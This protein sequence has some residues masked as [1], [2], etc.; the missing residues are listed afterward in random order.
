M[1]EQHR[2]PRAAARLEADVL[3]AG[4]GAAG[5]TAA[6][7]FGSAGFEVICVDRET[8]RLDPAD[9]GADLRTTAF[10]TPSVETLRRAGAWE[11]LAPHAAPLRV[12][13]LI[14]AGGARNVPRRTAD[15]VS[16]EV[17]DHPF[18][19]NLPN[20]V[21]RRAL[22]ERIE[23]LPNVRL[24]APAAL[25]RLTPR[26]NDAVA[27]LSDGAQVRARLVVAADG[28]DSAARRMLGLGARRWG[29]AQKALVFAVAHERPHE[30][31]STEIH[32][33]GGPFTLV[34]L[35][36]HEGRPCSSVVWME[37]G[38][39]AQ[40]LFEAPP[41][42]FEEA[43]NE[44]SCGVLG[45]LRPIGRRA[46]WPIVS[47]LAERL[48]GPRGA[49]M[50]EAAH[51]VPPIGAQGLNMSL[52]DAAALADLVARAA[53]AGEDIGAPALLARYHR[54]RWPEMSARV[55]G[56]DLLNRAAMAQAQPLRDLRAAGLTALHAAAPLRRLAMRL[57][58]GA[59]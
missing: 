25:T 31:V 36:D 42:A 32:R 11:R 12:M 29:Y 43:V 17:Q 40:A 1:S 28:R 41:E 16:D 49:L 34:P 37:R 58:M 51:V 59:R 5:L 8:P 56:I 2:S 6:A 52:A 50:G 21:I 18:G 48:D 7:L 14:D 9:P 53:A 26:L 10:L 38:P 23:E 44:R 55:A 27:Q 35:P 4:G 33:T 39:R 15:F 30:G 57:G 54:A 13:R 19:W 24:R 20:T 3:V 46:L 47:Q 45:R 22:L